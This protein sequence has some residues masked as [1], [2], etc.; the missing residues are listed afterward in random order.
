MTPI[1]DDLPTERFPIITVGLIVLN[2]VI[3]LYGVISASPIAGASLNEFWTLEYGL[4]P[5]ELIQDCQGQAEVDRLT[6]PASEFGVGGPGEVTIEIPS[7]SP[8]LTIFTA[9]FL[10]GGWL[11]LIGNMI[12]LWVYGNNVEDSMS[13]LRFVAFYLVGALAAALGQS[14]LVDPHAVIPMVGASGAIAACI[15]AYLRL[16]PRVQVLTMILLVFVPIF[17]RVPTI[18]VAGLWGIGQFVDTLASLYSPATGGVAYMAHLA[19]FVFGLA[20]IMLI[21]KRKEIYEQMYLRRQRYV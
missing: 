19:G 13:R 14:F 3:F 18:I 11:H 20:V 21:A 7:H 2:V 10:H 9:A 6:V 4:F 1:K 8:Y 5:C 15:G 12:F 17:I 16:Y